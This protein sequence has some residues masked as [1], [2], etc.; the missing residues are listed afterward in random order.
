MAVTKLPFF[1][2]ISLDSSKCINTADLH[3][4]KPI[5]FMYFGPNCEVCQQE[6]KELIKHL[7]ALQNIDIYMISNESTESSK[8]FSQFFRLDTIQNIFIGS[9]YD[10]TFFNIYS[11]N[12]IPFLAI[13]DSK[14]NLKKLYREKVPI[15]SII[16]AAHPSKE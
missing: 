6:T 12:S 15:T 13:Y 8:R 2:I 3:T 16:N 9:D 11:P 4:G 10:Y 1:K 7:D 5:L 14:K